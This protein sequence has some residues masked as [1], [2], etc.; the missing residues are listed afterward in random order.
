[1]SLK[2][3]DSL[4]YY[5]TSSYLDGFLSLEQLEEYMPGGAS[6]IMYG[7]TSNGKFVRNRF[8][9]VYSN[10][11]EE[12]SDVSIVEGDKIGWVTIVSIKSNL[13]TFA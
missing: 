8:F 11:C 2:D 9:W 5:S 6:L 3:G 1:M 4:T 7:R 13:Q 12:G 10:S